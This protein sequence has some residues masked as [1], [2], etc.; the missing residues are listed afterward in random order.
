M[1][2][3]VVNLELVTI[4]SWWCTLVPE[5][6][7]RLERRFCLF[8]WFVETKMSHFLSTVGFKFI[9]NVCLRSN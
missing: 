5:Y 7:D 3:T 6:G 4:G 2:K 8:F 1:R 9:F